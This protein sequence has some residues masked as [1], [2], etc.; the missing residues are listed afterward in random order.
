MEGN[1]GLSTLSEGDKPQTGDGGRWPLSK[2][3]PLWT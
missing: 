3:S 1:S 2:V